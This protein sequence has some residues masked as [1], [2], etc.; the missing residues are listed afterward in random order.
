MSHIKFSLA[1]QCQNYIKVVG[2]LELLCK[3]I[4]DGNLKVFKLEKELLDLLE[5]VN[6]EF[7]VFICLV[8][9]DEA[10]CVVIIFTTS[11]LLKRESTL[12]ILQRERNSS[13]EMQ[14]ELSVLR[15]WF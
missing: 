1:Q 7:E 10:Y 3:K 6:F 8:M 4:F 11:C 12:T 2:N 13:L 14:E 5:R 15:Q 9:V